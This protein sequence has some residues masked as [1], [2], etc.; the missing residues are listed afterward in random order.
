MGPMVHLLTV[1]SGF[2][3][4]LIRARLGADGVVCEIRGGVDGPYPV[5][6]AHLYVLA[7]DVE[8]ATALLDPVVDDEP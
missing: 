6:P 1:D 4:K 2:E 5:G 7:D 8:L 3:A